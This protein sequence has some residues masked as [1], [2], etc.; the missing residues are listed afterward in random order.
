MA[1]K[2]RNTVDTDIES[3]TLREIF[4]DPDGDG[5]SK[6][7]LLGAIKSAAQD[8]R[9]DLK[10]FIAR[11]VEHFRDQHYE[12]LASNP[13]GAFRIPAEAED[14]EVERIDATIAYLD[15]TPERNPYSPGFRPD[16][17]LGT[18]EE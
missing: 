2:K 8:A 12:E 18:N 11:A 3:L 10:T 9:V 15:P 5:D 1:K 14:V 7:W 16:I 13:Q 17:A 4:E 6:S